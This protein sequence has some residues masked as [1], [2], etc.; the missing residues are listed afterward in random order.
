MQEK[1]LE[2][3]ALLTLKE[4]LDEAH[5]KL[6]EMEEL[7]DQ[8]KVWESKMETEEAQ[9]L[10]MMQRLQEAKEKIR[11]LTEERNDFKQKQ[12][13]LEK[14]RDQLKEDIQ[15]TICMVS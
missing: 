5:Q 8:L 4:Q 15:D 14:E 1:D 6:S 9:K 10:D 12:E 13:D 7:K 3:E 2:Q 11:V